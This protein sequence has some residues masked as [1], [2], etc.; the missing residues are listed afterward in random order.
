[1]GHIERHPDG[2]AAASHEPRRAEGRLAGRH[3][4]R[5]ADGLGSSGDNAVSRGTQVV[6]H[7]LRTF[8]SDDQEFRAAVEYAYAG[9][10]GIKDVASRLEA[11]LQLT[12]PEAVVHDGTE[13]AELDLRPLYAY[14]YGS[15][16]ARG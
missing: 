6:A 9:L 1:M 10:G 12:Y 8:P 15:P 16:T 13:L 14:R 7:E 2:I 4:A 11:Y 5:L 3:D